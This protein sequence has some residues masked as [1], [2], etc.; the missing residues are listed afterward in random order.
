MVE[1]VKKV[2][3]L[4]EIKEEVVKFLSLL[5][6][7]KQF[8]NTIEL[9]AVVKYIIAMKSIVNNHEDS[10]YKNSLIFDIISIL[11]SLTGTSVRQYHYIFRSFIE[12]YHRSMLDLEDNDEMGVNQLFRSM[13]KKYGN[14]VESQIIIDFIANEYDESCLYVH[15]NTKAKTTVQMYYVD[16]INNDDFDED[17]LSSTITKTFVILKKMLELL[18]VSRPD[19]IENAFYRNKQKLKYLIGE[20]LYTLMLSRIRT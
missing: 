19:I 14:T 12:N 10:H 6:S 11:H 20:R 4:E 15:S 7:T 5:Q 17:T 18:I 9:Q 1:L 2:D 16:I 3:H 13:K 8:P